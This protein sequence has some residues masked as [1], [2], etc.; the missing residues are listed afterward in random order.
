MNVRLIKT[1]QIDVAH[2]LETFPE[3]HKCRRVHGHTMTVDV[4]L[5]GPVPE[6]RGYLVDFG[7]I[8][9]AVEPLRKQLDHHMLNEIEGLAVPTVENLSK[10]IYDRLKPALPLLVMIRVHETPQNACEYVGGL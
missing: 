10:W 5:E 8:K 3:G 7:E 9:Q 6:D 1:F 2:C 4:V